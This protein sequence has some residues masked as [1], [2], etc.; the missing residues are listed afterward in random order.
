MS[1]LTLLLFTLGA[2]VANLI[3]GL[4]LQRVQSATMRRALPELLAAFEHWSKAS[5][6][7]ASAEWAA[8]PDN[9]RNQTPQPEVMRKPRQPRQPKAAPPAPPTPPAPSVETGKAGATEL[10]VAPAAPQSTGYP[11]DFGDDDHR[12]IDVWANEGGAA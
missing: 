8:S 2:T 12:Q 11:K 5:S 6:A 7:R 10:A 3:A 1:A 4:L 9:P